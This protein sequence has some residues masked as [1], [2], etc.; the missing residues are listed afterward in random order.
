MPC[1]ILLVDNHQLVAEG[2]RALFAPHADLAV[3]GIAHRGSA[4]VSKA[5]ELLPDLVLMD[6]SLPND[7]EIRST[8]GA[9]GIEAAR[10]ILGAHPAIRILI[11]TAYMKEHWIEE[12]RRAGIAGYLSKDLSAETLVEA[13]RDT[14]E[15]WSRFPP[16]QHYPKLGHR[17]VKVLRFM[18]DGFTNDAIGGKLSVGRARVGQLITALFAKLDVDTRTS[19]VQ[20][21]RDLGY[22]PP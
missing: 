21:G 10:L 9:E 18:A 20:R 17:E 19:A 1:R 22:L 5:S 3:V 11:V 14:M 15:G 4:A 16:P 7:P 8:I 12:A 13:I 2:L 6:V